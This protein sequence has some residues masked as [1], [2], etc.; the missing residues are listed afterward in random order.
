[1]FLKKQKRINL[2]TI[3]LEKLEWQYDDALGKQVKT[4]LQDPVHF[5]FPISDSK[6]C[7]REHIQYELL[8]FCRRYMLMLL[9]HLRVMA[10]S[11]LETKATA[12]P[13]FF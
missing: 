2:N 3:F 11:N 1:M 10:L 9:Q 8:G 13:T 4:K 6:N 12:A 5:H 7:W